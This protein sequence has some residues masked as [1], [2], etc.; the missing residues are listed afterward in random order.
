MPSYSVG[1]REY[2]TDGKVSSV[3][4]FGPALSAANFDANVALAAALRA[5]ILAVQ[6]G[7]QREAVYG[8]TEDAGNADLPTDPAAQRENKWLV[9]CREAAGGL[10]PVTFTIP[11]ADLDQLAA[12]GV[13]MATGANRTALVSAVEDFV[14]SNDGTAVVVESIKFRARTLG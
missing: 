13:N 1:I 5:A 14:K 3:K 4:V 10:N 2:G 9:S 12:D 6:L 8:H 7:E 11:C